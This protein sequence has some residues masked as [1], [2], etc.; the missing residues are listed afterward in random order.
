VEIT[1]FG[2][3]TSKNSQHHIGTFPDVLTGFRGCYTAGKGGQEMD[4]KGKR[5]FLLFPYQFLDSS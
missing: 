5:D 3:K 2:D 1:K 4:K